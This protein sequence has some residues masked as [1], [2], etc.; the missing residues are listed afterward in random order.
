[1]LWCNCLVEGR[2]VISNQMS[3]IRRMIIPWKKNLEQKFHLVEKKSLSALQLTK[4]DRNITKDRSRT[5]DCVEQ[6]YQINE[7]SK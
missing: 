1:M 4:N 7:L 3:Y 2:G 5:Q 6:K